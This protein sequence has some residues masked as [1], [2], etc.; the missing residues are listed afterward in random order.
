MD[1]AAILSSLAA[2]SP[3]RV[4]DVMGINTVV[5]PADLSNTEDLNKQVKE[6]VEEGK[7][8]DIS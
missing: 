5:G 8:S 6:V 2:Q 1:G 4:A 3:P 7:C